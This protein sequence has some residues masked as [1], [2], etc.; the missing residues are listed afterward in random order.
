MKYHLA[1][2][3]VAR[4]VAELEDPIMKEFVDNLDRINALAEQSP[5][6]VWRFQ[7]E[8]GDATAERA[9]DDQQILVNMSV[10]ESIEALKQYVYQSTHVEFL[11]RKKQW[12]TTF[13]KPYVVLWWIPADHTPTVAEAKT[14][15][16]SLTDQGPTSQAFTFAKP[17]PPPA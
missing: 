13:G 4:M 8:E 6:F 12:F 2:L 16:Q 7:T 5:G 10:W 9:F 11:R 15:L 14:K 17:F 1:Q 3:N